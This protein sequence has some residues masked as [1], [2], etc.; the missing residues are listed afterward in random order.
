MNES[1]EVIAEKENFLSNG[2]KSHLADMFRQ[3][4][5]D[6]FDKVNNY[7]SDL[8]NIPAQVEAYRLGMDMGR[9]ITTGELAFKRGKQS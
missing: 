4:I 5:S 7:P 9:R 6:H 1:E 8:H 3:G 2:V